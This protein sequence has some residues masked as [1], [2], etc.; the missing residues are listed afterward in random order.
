MGYLVSDTPVRIDIDKMVRGTGHHVV[1][2]GNASLFPLRS[3]SSSS[4]KTSHSRELVPQFS[5]LKF[6]IHSH[7]M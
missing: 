7:W 4:N 3:S 1:F 5:K 6:V 2:T